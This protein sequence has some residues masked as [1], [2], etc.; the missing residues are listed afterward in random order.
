M[1]ILC[2]FIDG[3]ENITPQMKDILRLHENHPKYC[4]NGIMSSMGIFILYIYIIASK[5]VGEK[6]SFS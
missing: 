1:T 5:K 4:E 3:L 6:L 2:N